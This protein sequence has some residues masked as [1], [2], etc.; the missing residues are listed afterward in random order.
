M[1]IRTLECGQILY[2]IFGTLFVR[3]ANYLEKVVCEIIKNTNKKERITL[4]A[5]GTSGAICCGYVISGL[6]NAGYEN[7]KII[8][9]RKHVTHHDYPRQEAEGTIIF[10]DDIIETGLTL[11][12]V[13]EEYGHIN[14]AFVSTNEIDLNEYISKRNYELISQNVDYLYL[15]S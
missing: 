1:E 10:V 13:I 3:D 8:L 12:S 11:A 14:Y 2:P 7:V 9:S 6:Y 15:G 4:I 5:R